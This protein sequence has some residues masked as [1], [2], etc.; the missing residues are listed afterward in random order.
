MAKKVYVGL[1]GGVDSS[2]T[3]ALLKDRGYEVTAV[4]MKNWTKDI[5]GFICPWQEDYEDAKRVAVNLNVPL[6]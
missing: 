1:S 3:T 4:Y 2:L 6:K 5:P